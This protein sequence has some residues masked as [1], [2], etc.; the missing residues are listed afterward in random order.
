MQLNLPGKT[1]GIQEYCSESPIL[2]MFRIGT[3]KKETRKDGACTA[4]SLSQTQRPD[5]KPALRSL[6]S[7]CR[8]GAQCHQPYT[9]ASLEPAQTQAADSSCVCIPLLSPS[10]VRTNEPGWDGCS[11]QILGTEEEIGKPTLPLETT[12]KIHP[13]PNH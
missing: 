5:E 10:P 13:V 12:R 11:T 3:R 9:P 6:Q 2:T 4:W 8:Q 7:G 1:V